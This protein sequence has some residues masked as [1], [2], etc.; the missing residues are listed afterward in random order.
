[1]TSRVRSTVLFLCLPIMGQLVAHA[2][3]I[4]PIDLT[5][6]GGA[7]TGNPLQSDTILGS[8]TTDGTI[9]ALAASDIVSWNLDL[10]DNLNPANSVDLTLANS[11]LIADIGDA[12][13]ASATSLSFNYGVAGAGFGIQANVPGPY[14]GYSYFCLDSGW[15]ACAVGETISPQYVYADGVDLTGANAP[16]GDQPLGPPASGTSVTPEPSSLLLLGSGIAGLV[17]MARRRIAGPA[18]VV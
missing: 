14:S 18:R 16:V 1:M 6:T 10:I 3:S 2:D 8:I 15:Y 7:L 5:I 13:I 4:Y 12:L 9:G 17:G 11:A